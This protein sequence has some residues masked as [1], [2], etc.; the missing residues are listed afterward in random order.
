M[1]CGG[2]CRWFPNGLPPRTI[3]NRSLCQRECLPR[4]LGWS[5]LGLQRLLLELLLELWSEPR[6]LVE[7]RLELQ[8]LELELLEAEPESDPFLSALGGTAP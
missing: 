5:I 4:I 2:Q 3:A 1:S 7:F 6:Q 8:Q